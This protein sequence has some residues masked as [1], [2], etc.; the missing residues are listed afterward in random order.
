MQEQQKVNTPY[1]ITSLRNQS[2]LGAANSWTGGMP[3]IA[4]QQLSFDGRGQPTTSLGITPGALSPAMAQYRQ[5][6]SGGGLGNSSSA[7][8]A[9]KAM[10]GGKEV[11]LPPPNLDRNNIDPLTG[12]PIINS[13]SASRPKPVAQ[14]EKIDKRGILAKQRE[15]IQALNNPN[16]AWIIGQTLRGVPESAKREIL[17]PIW[18]PYNKFIGQPFANTV[19]NL[20][21]GITE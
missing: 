11:P 20:Y 14:E 1:D 5:F 19:H 16:A 21:K 12:Q 13:S 15:I 7:P 6:L 17:D 4:G 2:V 8:V 10:S 3:P 9:S 18:K